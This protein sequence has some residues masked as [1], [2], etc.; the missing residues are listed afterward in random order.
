MLLAAPAAKGA[1]TGQVERISILTPQG[2]QA[3]LHLQLTLQ[4]QH[5]L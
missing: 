1:R 2:P 5:V 4:L 3:G